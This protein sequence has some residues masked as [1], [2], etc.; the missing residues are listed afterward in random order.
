MVASGIVQGSLLI[1]GQK[2]DVPSLDEPLSDGR[3]NAFPCSAVGNVESK[4]RIV[5]FENGI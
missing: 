1:Q 4:I 5:I 3:E 2:V